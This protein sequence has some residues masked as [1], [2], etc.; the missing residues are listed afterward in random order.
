LK[1]V[2][3]PRENRAKEPLLYQRSGLQVQDRGADDFLALEKSVR[4]LQM[5]LGDRLGELKTL[6]LDLAHRQSLAQKWRERGDLVLLYRALV[7]TGLEPQ[8]ARDYVEMAAESLLA[9]G[10]DLLEQLARTVGPTVKILPPERPLPKLLAFLGPTGA[11]KTTSLMKLAAFLRQKGLKVAAISL[12]TV[13]LGAAEQLAQFARL[14]GL[15]L[16]VCQSRAEFNEALD[17][18]SDCDHAL[19]DTSAR[20]FLGK[21]PQKDLKGVLA[22]SGAFHFLVLPASLKSEDLA[23]AYRGA[24]GPFLLAVILSKLDETRNLGSVFNFLRAQSPTLGYFSN[25]YKPPEDFM[26]A[27][28]SKLLE[29]WLQGPTASLKDYTP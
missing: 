28:C 13:K 2:P 17:L 3:A 12:D 11:G 4:D 1:P 16:K 20:D 10:G 23:E 25:G 18:F 6:L 26:V 24:K 27:S 21:S 8:N 14:A 22:E 5:D 29:L 15:G 19:V 9:W 7:E